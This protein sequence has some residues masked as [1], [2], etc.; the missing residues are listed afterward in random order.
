[1][2]AVNDVDI[3]AVLPAMISGAINR[4]EG[5]HLLINLLNAKDVCAVIWMLESCIDYLDKMIASGLRIS[6]AQDQD[7]LGINSFD[8]SRVLHTMIAEVRGHLESG[9][10]AY[11][12]NKYGVLVGIVECLAAETIRLCGSGFPE[13]VFAKSN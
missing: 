13:P 7:L 9:G 10:G 8:R 6:I 2:R 1:M 5:R 3:R 4:K 11:L 12:S